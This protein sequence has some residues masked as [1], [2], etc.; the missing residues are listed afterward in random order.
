MGIFGRSKKKQLSTV[1]TYVC[2]EGQKDLADSY[3]EKDAKELEIA[4][5]NIPIRDSSGKINS[6]S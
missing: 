6:D 2:R 3:E 1:D 4:T 5:R